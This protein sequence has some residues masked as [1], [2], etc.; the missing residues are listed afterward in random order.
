M[1]ASELQPTSFLSAAELRDRLVER[2][3]ALR[4]LQREVRSHDERLERLQEDADAIASVSRIVSTEDEL[5]EVKNKVAQIDLAYKSIEQRS[6]QMKSRP[7][8]LNA[9]TREAQLTQQLAELSSALSATETN[10]LKRI[11]KASGELQD[12]LRLIEETREEKITLL[13]EELADARREQ[14]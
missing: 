1:S 11:S 14:R 8:P 3:G 6:A 7:T 12:K 2:R 4:Q 10:A 13:E 5:S 9:Q